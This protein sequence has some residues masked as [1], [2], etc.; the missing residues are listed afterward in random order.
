L[1]WLALS[2]EMHF[3]VARTAGFS[4]T[5]LGGQRPRLIRCRPGTFSLFG[6][7]SSR[8]AAR[9]RVIVDE[10]A[11]DVAIS[12]H[13]N[14]LCDEAIVEQA[15]QCRAP[16]A[17]RLAATSAPGQRKM[18]RASRLGKA[19]RNWSTLPRTSVEWATHRPAN[20]RKPAADFMN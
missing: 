4:F 17:C 9:R 20:W 7:D 15:G 13:G 19:H 16:N 14:A 12:I 10:V 6:E 3:L 1:F 5:G 18:R 11:D 8:H 2:G